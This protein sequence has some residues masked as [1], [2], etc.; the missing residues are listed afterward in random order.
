VAIKVRFELN[1]KNGLRR[2]VF[3]LQKD[4]QGATIHWKIDFALFERDKK[5]D[6]Y[7]DPLVSLVVEVDTKLNAKAE[8]A[9][10]DGL[11][12]AQAAHALGPAADDAKDSAAGELDAGEAKATVQATLNRR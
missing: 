2:I 4:T 7:G 6:T 11:T 10:R 9:A 1:A 5:T 3:G 8:I 12:P